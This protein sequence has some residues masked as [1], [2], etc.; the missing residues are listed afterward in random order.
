MGKQK[1][2]EDVLEGQLARIIGGSAQTLMQQ[3]L[4]RQATPPLPDFGQTDGQTDRQADEQ[5]SGQTHGQPNGH[6]SGQTD[7]RTL[8]Q[9]PEQA[10]G[11]TFGHSL[12]QS[13]LDFLLGAKRTLFEYLAA[14]DGLFE[15]LEDTAKRLEMPY[16]TLR[17]ALRELC[18]YGLVTTKKTRR[19]SLQGLVYR[20]SLTAPGVGQTF[21]HSLGQAVGQAHGHT[22]GQ[23]GRRT[24]GHSPSKIDREKDLSSCWS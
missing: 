16:G 3:T 15:R 6:T 4:D 12:G 22:F 7:R 23:A 20:V 1:R 8:G 24:D 11:Q 17:N 18:K 2:Y 13:P 9:A 14:N 19:F 5:A 21:G 10:H